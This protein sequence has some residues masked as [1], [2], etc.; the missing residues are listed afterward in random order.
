ME[1]SF[2]SA[3][4]S[5]QTRTWKSRPCLL[6]GKHQPLQI[7]NA[8]HAGEFCG[9]LLNIRAHA[10]RELRAEPA[11][12][13]FPD[14]ERRAKKKAFNV[15]D[16]DVVVP[17]AE[18]QNSSVVGAPDGGGPLGCDVPEHDPTVSVA[19]QQARVVAHKA[20]GMNLGSM[21]AQHVSRVG[22]WTLRLLQVQGAGSRRGAGH[23]SA[24]L[25]G[26]VA[27]VR[28]EDGGA[29]KERRD[30]EDRGEMIADKVQLGATRA[31]RVKLC[32]A[33]SRCPSADVPG[34]DFI[35]EGTRVRL[36]FAATVRCRLA[37]E[38]SQQVASHP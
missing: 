14:A 31:R 30:E 26:F 12:H 35:I 29:K 20:N 34:A 4:R 32:I 11:R 16:E 2:S 19:R 17:S 9:G 24:R 33:M 7:L 5:C 6:R 13:K 18:A 21:A 28:R 37:R 22:G 8:V 25:M 27:V 1:K 15:R 10:C 3:G 23:L 36:R 38:V